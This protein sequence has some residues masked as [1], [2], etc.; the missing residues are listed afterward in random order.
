MQTGQI[1]IQTTYMGLTLVVIE[2]LIDS[3]PSVI[4]NHG[5]S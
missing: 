5:T 1:Y 4:K 3:H 2:H